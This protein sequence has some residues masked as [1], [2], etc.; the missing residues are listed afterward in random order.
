MA[1]NA[2][3]TNS[4]SH[5]CTSPLAKKSTGSGRGETVACTGVV[6]GETET[7]EAFEPVQL[8]LSPRTQRAPLAGLLS[9]PQ[10]DRGLSW[11]GEEEEGFSLSSS[12]RRSELSPAAAES[13][14]KYTALD[15]DR[16]H[17]SADELL[18]LS[19]PFTIVSCRRWW[20]FC[21]ERAMSALRFVWTTMTVTITLIAAFLAILTTFWALSPICTSCV[22]SSR[23]SNS[24][25]AVTTADERGWSTLRINQLQVRV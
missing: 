25:N 13:V 6:G 8:T 22:R 14:Q 15:G 23:R 3:A 10:Q 19:D 5:Q 4:Q 2:A 18:P 12:A 20:G 24:G 11:E 9:F 16:H 21:E 1:T 7:I 17:E